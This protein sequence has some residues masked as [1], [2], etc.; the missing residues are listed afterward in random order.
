MTPRAPTAL[1]HKRKDGG[2]MSS[3]H[4]RRK[5]VPFERRCKSHSSNSSSPNPQSMSQRL[6]GHRLSPKQSSNKMPPHQ[7]SYRVCPPRRDLLQTMRLSSRSRPQEEH[8]HHLWIPE[9][10]RPLRRRDQAHLDSRRLARRRQPRLK[11]MN[12]SNSL[13][14]THHRTNRQPS[15]IVLSS[16]T[17]T[18]FTS[19]ILHRPGQS[20]PP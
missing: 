11:L 2:T 1:A 3:P 15:D 20:P 9:R 16:Q 14:L 5:R 4:S 18:L 12:H 10:R 6:L 8:H 19:F 7:S 13:H 17:G